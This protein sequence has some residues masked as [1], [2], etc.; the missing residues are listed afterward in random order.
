MATE[1]GNPEKIRYLREHL[2][3]EREMLKYT[4]ARLHD[5]QPGIAWNVVYESFGIHARNLYDF[6]RN[7]GKKGNTFR[8]DYYVEGWGRAPSFLGFNKLDSFLFH[9][10]TYR[11]DHEKLDLG[12][13]Q[14]LG[15]W[16][17]IQWASWVSQLH[18]DYSGILDADPVCAPPSELGEGISQSTACTALTT[19]SAVFTPNHSQIKE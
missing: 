6:F 5:T 11:A 8:A 7:E 14:M 16:I 1:I 4:F 19:V 12:T 17:D 13:L 2:A 10:S 15:K 9:M 3:Y 18:T